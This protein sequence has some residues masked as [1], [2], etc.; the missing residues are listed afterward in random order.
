MKVGDATFLESFDE[1]RRELLLRDMGRYISDEQIH[2]RGELRV[3]NLPRR[4]RTASKGKCRADM[5]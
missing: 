4:L 3:S 2:F 1:R 5:K